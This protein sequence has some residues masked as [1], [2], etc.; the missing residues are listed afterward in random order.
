MTS[1]LLPPPDSS[2]CA[3]LLSRLQ[4]VGFAVCPD[5]CLQEE[6]GLFHPVTLN[7]TELN[8]RLEWQWNKRVAT[9]VA[10]RKDF[11]GLGRVDT[12]TTC[13]LLSQLS[14]EDQALLRISL[15]GGLFTQ[16]AHSHWNEGTGS[17]KWCGQLDSLQH[18]YFECV[19]TLDVRQQHA[20][21]LVRVRQWVPD[22]P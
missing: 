12:I 18:R 13:Q 11:G 6:I 5:G 4:T 2:P 1:V 8:H 19:N 15:A 14:K 17:C 22:A 21:D 9:A 16:D 10:H 20:P 7:Y 3:V